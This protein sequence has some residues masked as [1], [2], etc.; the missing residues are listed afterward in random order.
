MMFSSCLFN[1]TQTALKF[2]LSPIVQKDVQEVISM[3]KF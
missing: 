2:L 3:K 1:T